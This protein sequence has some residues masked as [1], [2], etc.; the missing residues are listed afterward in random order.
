MFFFFYMR[1]MH[2]V[3]PVLNLSA[4]D[5]GI[6]I[7]VQQVRLMMFSMNMVDFSMS[8]LQRPNSLFPFLDL[9]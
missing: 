2:L 9:I 4:L 7:M 1:D 5:A 6:L 8:F 3:L